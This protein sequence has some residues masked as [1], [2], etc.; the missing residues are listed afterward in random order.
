MSI[1]LCPA[2]ADLWRVERFD[3][4]GVALPSAWIEPVI[5]LA[6]FAEG[7]DGRFAAVAPVVSTHLCS[8]TAEAVDPDDE[9]VTVRFGREHA[10]RFAWEWVTVHLQVVQKSPRYAGHHLVI[11]KSH[12]D[13]QTT[14]LQVVHVDGCPRCAAENEEAQQEVTG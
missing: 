8:D 6:G 4:I 5:A 10:E 9:K 1:C 14:A 3:P 11:E 13:T 7:S 2:P 12:P